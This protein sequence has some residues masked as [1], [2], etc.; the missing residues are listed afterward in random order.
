M[1][2][3]MVWVGLR[4]RVMVSEHDNHVMTDGHPY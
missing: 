2:G 1:L 4:F 3:F